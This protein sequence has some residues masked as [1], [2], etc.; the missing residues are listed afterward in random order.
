MHSSTS[1]NSLHRN[2]TQHSLS[3]LPENPVEELDN[4]RS[5]DS[6]FL[7]DGVL[8]ARDP[9]WSELGQIQSVYLLQLFII[10]MIIIINVDDALAL[11]L[12]A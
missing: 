12:S 5:E 4:D 1:T 8:T 2:N 10:I 9:R 11:S 3:L 7:I 6:A